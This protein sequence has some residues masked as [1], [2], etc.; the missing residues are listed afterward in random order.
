MPVYTFRGT[1][2]SGAVIS[3]ERVAANKTELAAM[4]RRDQ[5][6]VSKMSEKGREFNIPTFGTGV[7]AK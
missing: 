4:L 1:N 3:G 6:N 7:D 2:R 5:I